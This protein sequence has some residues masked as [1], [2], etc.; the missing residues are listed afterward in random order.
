MKIGDV[1]MQINKFSL[2]FPF[3]FFFFTLVISIFFNF[4]FFILYIVQP[5][6]PMALP[7]GGDA[8][9]QGFLPWWGE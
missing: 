8:A 2:F 9:V 3:F 6:D 7:D 4:Y 5:I 1:T